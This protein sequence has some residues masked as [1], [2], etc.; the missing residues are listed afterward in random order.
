MIVMEGSFKVIKV[1]HKRT[2]NLGETKN[3][4]NVKT[5]LYE[6]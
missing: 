6:R 1:V 4:L 3:V 2:L 5:R